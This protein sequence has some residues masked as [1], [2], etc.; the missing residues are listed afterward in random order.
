MGYS[1]RVHER[2]SHTEIEFSGVLAAEAIVSILDE[3]NWR[4]IRS[5]L[6]GLLWD[7][8]RADLSAYRF[9]DMARLRAYDGAEAGPAEGGLIPPRK[10]RIAAVFNGHSNQLILRLWETS[11]EPSDGLERRS[12]EDIEVARR[13]IAGP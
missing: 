10:F 11:S 1:F 12:F 2:S 9:E 6:D 7:L 5:S 4:R 8:R 13:W 3:I